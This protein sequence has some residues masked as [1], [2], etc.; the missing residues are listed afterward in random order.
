MTLLET[1]RS[2]FVLMTMIGIGDFPWL[3][4]GSAS[5]VMTRIPHG[6][7]TVFP[8]P[9]ASLPIISFRRAVAVVVTVSTR[10]VATMF[11]TVVMVIM[12]MLMLM[13]VVLGM[14][15]VA[16]TPMLIYI[17][18]IRGI[19]CVP[20]GGLDSWLLLDSSHVNDA[21]IARGLF[22]GETDPE[23]LAR[24]LRP[25][26]LYVTRPAIAAVAILSSLFLPSDHHGGSSAGRGRRG[27]RRRPL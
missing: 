24:E 20:A 1:F 12:M 15:V 8:L 9:K 17:L 18:G 14:T 2:V 4:F 10:A 26:T 13:M 27:G 11:R 3:R 5:M 25:S 6:I 22:V 7:I 19:H 16:P 23:H 21:D